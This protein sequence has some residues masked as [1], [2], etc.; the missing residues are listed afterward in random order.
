MRILE[1]ARPMSDSI[2]FS[3]VSTVLEIVQV[4]WLACTAMSDAYITSDVLWKGL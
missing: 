1:A 4:N 3:A 2:T